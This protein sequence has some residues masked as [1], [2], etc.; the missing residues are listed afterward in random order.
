MFVHTQIG[1][2]SGHAGYEIPA[3]GG[4]SSSNCVW[5]KFGDEWYPWTLAG[6]SGGE[7]GSEDAPDSRWFHSRIKSQGRSSTTIMGIVSI[8]EYISYTHAL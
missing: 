8:F 6:I 4:D 2:R 3:I 5:F 7:T 1:C